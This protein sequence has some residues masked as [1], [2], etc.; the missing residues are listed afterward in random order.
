MTP[1]KRLLDL[2]VLAVI[3]PFVLVL[4]AIAAGMVWAMDGRP[5]LHGAERMRSPSRGFTLW[6]LRTMRPDP[7][8]TGVSGADKTRRITRSGRILRRL[9][10]DE[11]PQIWNI[12]RGD[13]SFVGPRPPLRQYVEKF[14]ELYAQVLQARPGITGLASLVY[15]RHEERLLAQCATSAETDAVYSRRCVPRKARLDL[16]YLANRSA[17]TDLWLIG[18][19]AAQA[20]RLFKPARRLPR[21]RRAASVRADGGAN[22]RRHS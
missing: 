7:G 22:H 2:V 8:D 4:L 5:I 13:A 9:R 12:L 15:H 1:G 10:F 17:A 20:L 18:L 16:I 11:L 14:P 6:K 19:T 21:F 3:G